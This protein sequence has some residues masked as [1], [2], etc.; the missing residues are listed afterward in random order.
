MQRVVDVEDASRAY[1]VGEDSGNGCG[2]EGGVAEASKGL[3]TWP[4]E[5]EPWGEK[6]KSE[7]ECGRG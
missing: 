5:V 1:E 4:R 7:R 6:E 2:L 3:E